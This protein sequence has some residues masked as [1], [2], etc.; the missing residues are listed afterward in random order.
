MTQTDFAKALGLRSYVAV[1]L[2]EKR[3]QPKMRGTTRER[4][5]DLLDL[6]GEE[7][8][9]RMWRAGEIPEVPPPKGNGTGQAWGDSLGMYRALTVY[10]RRDDFARLEDA[11]RE[12]DTTPE[13]IASDMVAYCLLS[14]AKVP[15]RTGK[16]YRVIQA[17]VSVRPP[18]QLVPTESG[19]PPRKP[20]EEPRG[21]REQ[22]RRGR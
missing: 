2:M 1:G 16:V 22:E 17:D 18:V 3:D 10:V 6:S 4:L 7:E 8:L 13:R 20:A 14:D 15:A 11:A 19:P 12:Q 5:I 21:A 9:E